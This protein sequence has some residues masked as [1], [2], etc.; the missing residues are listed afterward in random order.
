MAGKRKEEQEAELNTMDQLSKSIDLGTLHSFRFLNGPS[1]RLTSDFAKGIKTW[2]L[3]MKSN[4][5]LQ[6]VL[7]MMESSDSFFGVLRD[8]GRIADSTT[9]VLE[10]D[11][12]V[13]TGETT[14]SGHVDQ[15]H[16][17]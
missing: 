17:F 13:Q 7:T 4:E 3:S 1:I 10:R 11:E 6:I 15:H 5:R 14:N 8:F 9:T 12:L 16:L 2:L